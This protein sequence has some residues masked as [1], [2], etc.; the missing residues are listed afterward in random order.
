MRLCLD[1]IE[2]IRDLLVQALRADSAEEMR[3]AIA[4]V[5]DVM[6]IPHA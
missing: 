5:L 4:K 3:A 6:G 2:A 1:K